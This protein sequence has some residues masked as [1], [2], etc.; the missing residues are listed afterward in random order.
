L[1]EYEAVSATVA[2]LP[3]DTVSEPLPDPLS[4][5]LFDPTFD[6]VDSVDEDPFAHFARLPSDSYVTKLD[7]W[8]KC[9]VHNRI[10]W[11]EFVAQ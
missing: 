8:N 2:E 5:P 7:A 3:L 6:D 9:I 11:A 1:E 4:D 10:D